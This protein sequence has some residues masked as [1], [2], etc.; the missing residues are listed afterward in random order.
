M[1]VCNRAGCER[2]TPKARTRPYKYCSKSCRQKAYDSRTGRGKKSR[3]KP[4][5]IIAIDSETVTDEDGS[6]RL[7]LIAAS[8][9]SYIEGHDIRTDEALEYFVSRPGELWSFYGDYD[10]N[11]WLRDL[12]HNALD[13]LRLENYTAWKHWRIRHIPRRSFEVWNKQTGA[14]ARMYDVFPFVQCSYVKWLED[15]QLAPREV[16]DRIYLMKQRREDFSHESAEDIRA[17]TF[18]EVEYMAKGVRLLKRR[19]LASGYAP[20]QWLGPGAVAATALR[21]HK[22]KDYYGDIESEEQYVADLAYYGGRVE[23]S[24]V[25]LVPGPV[26]SYDINSAYPAAAAALP[27]LA[28]NKWDWVQE[29]PDPEDI[30]LVEIAWSSPNYPERWG[31][32][33]YRDAPGLTLK[34]PAQ[35]A[36]WYWW[37]E[38]YPWLERYD[39]R[40]RDA[41]I[42]RQRCQHKP[43]KW[44]ADLYHER[45]ELK[46][47][48]DPAEYAYKLILNSCYG[49]LAQRVGSKPFLNPIWAGIITSK[50][51]AMLG[52]ILAQ[53]PDD[54]YTVAT[55]GILSRRPLDLD[56]GKGLGQWSLDATYEWADIWQPGFYFLPDVEDGYIARTRG[57][58][59]YEVELNDFRIAWERVGPLAYVEVPRRR[60]L[61]YRLAAFQGRTEQLGE[62]KEE[63]S[64]LKFWPWPRRWDHGM[65][66]YHYDGEARDW[67]RTIAPLGDFRPRKVIDQDAAGFRQMRREME[68]YDDGLPVGEARD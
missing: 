30:A 23:I 56:F 38:V 51:R 27:C 9:Y 15:W 28:C 65:S 10:I 19:V 40:L 52:E 50:T 61:G 45:Q 14:Y 41:A 53:Y 34:Y 54:I 60:S 32:L 43:M 8:D 22:V 24:A 25:G 66:E 5:E 46:A 20:N 2:E 18:D 13:R 47:K 44:L 7:I 42:L 21:R 49:K 29:W 4:K 16:I 1:A 68:W 35:G 26:Y 12:D 36:G 57:F 55:D 39:F 67:L 3:A 64:K 48:G 33:P 11:Y 31:P 17:Y 63:Y 59:V 62:W 58:T 6:G 37:H